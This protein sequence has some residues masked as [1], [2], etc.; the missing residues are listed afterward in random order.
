[1][2]TRALRLTSV[3][4]LLAACGALF[5]LS[6]RTGA[7]A[8]VPEAGQEM[9]PTLLEGCRNAVSSVKSGKGRVTIY[10][11]YEREDERILET[12]TSYN[13][14]FSGERFRLSVSERIL[15][16]TFESALPPDQRRLSPGRVLRR[17]VAYDGEKVTTLEV[18]EGTATV[19]EY[20]FQD[21]GVQDYMSVQ[22]APSHVLCEV[23]KVGEL[24]GYTI[25]ELR[26]VG[27]EPVNGDECLVIELTRK[28]SEGRKTGGLFTYWLWVSPGKGFTV[29]RTRCWVEGGVTYKEKTLISQDDAEEVRQY[30]DVWGPAK[31]TL[32][33]HRINGETG[34]YYKNGEETITYSPDFQVNVP[35][36]GEELSLVLPPGTKVYNKLLDEWSVVP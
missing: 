34:E 15:Q 21:H 32:V 36:T 26:I 6:A 33:E 18:N 19:G 31:V 35:L 24:P 10:E 25:G 17:E 2:G 4:I 1:M 11:R 29:P 20:K 9:L 22:F 30:G 8:F 12:E 13:L 14:W 3:V 5:L 23:E 16:C 28:P 27:R 7:E